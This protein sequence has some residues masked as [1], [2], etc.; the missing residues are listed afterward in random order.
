VVLNNMSKGNVTVLGVGR[1]GICMALSCER[2]GYN[3]LGVDVITSY[4]NQLNDKT[5]VSSEPLVTP[6]LKESKNFKATDSLDEGLAFSD[7]LFILLATPTGSGDKSYD[8]TALSNLLSKINDR[9]I[10]NKHIMIGCT[11]LPGYIANTARFL[12]RDCEN[13][14]ISYNPE[15]IAQG[16]VMHGLVNPDMVLIGEGNKE[17]GDWLE[18]MYLSV[19]DN[20]PAIHRMSPESAEITKLSV[21]CFIT[22]KIAFANMIGDVANRTPNADADTILRAVGADSRIGSKYIRPGYGFGGPCFPRDNR[23]LG[24]YIRSTG[25]EPIIPF[26]T[27]NANKL[28]ARVMA[29]ALLEKNLDEYVFND[30]CY[31]TKC[32]VP[33]IEESQPLEV[34]RLLVKA[35]KR[36]KI[37]DRKDVIRNVQMEFGNLFEYEIADS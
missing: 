6:Y 18:D 15:F 31:K 3:V 13:C 21:N 2:K 33:I 9:K 32:P 4:V 23:A 20:K 1:L 29:D 28:H 22:T 37:S 19:C 36:V 8:H 7:K 5:F 25:I 10:K 24:N 35:G 14:S 26:A 12:I 11:V 27:D 34:A 30:V 17:I 16:D